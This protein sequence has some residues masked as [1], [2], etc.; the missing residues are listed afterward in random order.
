[1]D[2]GVPN[3]AEIQQ[4]ELMMWHFVDTGSSKETL[5]EAKRLGIKNKKGNDSLSVWSQRLPYAMPVFHPGHFKDIV[6]YRNSPNTGRS[7]V[8]LAGDYTN[9]S[10]TE[11]AAFSGRLA[12]RRILDLS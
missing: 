10:C 8:V 6:R 2:I 3:A 5:L 7:R 12:A 4:V 1:V 9:L 11:G